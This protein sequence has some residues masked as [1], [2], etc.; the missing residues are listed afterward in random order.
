MKDR[1]TW[2]DAL[3]RTRVTSIYVLRFL[4]WLFSLGYTST[5]SGKSDY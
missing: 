5:R 4:L 2:R 3:M 1:L